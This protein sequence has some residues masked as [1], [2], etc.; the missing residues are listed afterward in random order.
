MWKGLCHLALSIGK[1]TVDFI[2]LTPDPWLNKWI[3]SVPPCIIYYA[4]LKC[5]KRILTEHVSEKVVYTFEVIG[6]AKEATSLIY[7]WG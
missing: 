6:D 1:V 7:Y 4:E 5:F 3:D 2:S